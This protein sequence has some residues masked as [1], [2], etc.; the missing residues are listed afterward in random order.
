MNNIFAHH[1]TPRL[2]SCYRTKAKN[3]KIYLQKEKKNQKNKEE[4][5]EL[6][7]ANLLLY[8]KFANI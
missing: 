5:N 4:K 6:A 2:A 8:F 3:E 1:S 7:L